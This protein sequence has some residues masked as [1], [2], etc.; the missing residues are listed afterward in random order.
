MAGMLLS[1]PFRIL[2]NGS[3]AA[4]DDATEEYM[5]ERIALLLATTQGER[6]LVPDF[7]VGDL[8][9]EG[10]TQPALANQC[11]LFD[12]PVDIIE[13]RENV[14]SAEATDYT[15]VFD[16]PVTEAEDD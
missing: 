9:Y 1:H 2:P 4:Y 12:L 16:I 8:A 14:L 3:A 13:V 15:V 7:G 11:D 5:A 10:L 6:P